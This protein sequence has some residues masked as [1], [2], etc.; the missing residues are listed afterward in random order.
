MKPNPFA[1][2]NHFTVPLGIEHSSAPDWR[3]S[4]TPDLCH[5]GL[6]GQCQGHPESRGRQPLHRGLARLGGAQAPHRPR[7]GQLSRLLHGLSGRLPEPEGGS[8]AARRQR[9]QR[10]EGGSPTAR[11]GGK[12]RKSTR[13]NSSH[14]NISYAVFC[15][16]KKKDNLAAWTRAVQ[17]CT[18]RVRGRQRTE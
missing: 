13:L 11:V 2:L 7:R 1:S 9:D 4:P 3:R 14:A 8:L 12:D 16:K 6:A 5:P 10:T 17:P 15:L 18:P